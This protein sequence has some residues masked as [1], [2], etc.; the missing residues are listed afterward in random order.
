MCVCDVECVSVFAA[1]VPV[2]LRG[3]A[4]A[5]A[6]RARVPVTANQLSYRIYVLEVLFYRADAMSLCTEVTAA[7]V[8]IHLG[9]Q[10][11]WGGFQQLLSKVPMMN[12]RTRVP[13]LSDQL[14]VFK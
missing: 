14:Q 5:P 4:R 10:H 6:P 11:C 9:A 12:R 13:S 1:L 8:P 7:P 3:F 2:F